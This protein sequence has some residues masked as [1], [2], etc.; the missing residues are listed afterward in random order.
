MY[1]N[2]CKAWGKPCAILKST[3]RKRSRCILE[4]R[5]QP[6]GSTAALNSD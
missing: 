3:A 1:K 6:D 5:N 2:P 4:T